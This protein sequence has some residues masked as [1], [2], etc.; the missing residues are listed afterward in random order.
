[1]Y[2]MVGEIVVSPDT[3]N[4]SS[5]LLAV[6]SRTHGTGGWD[7]VGYFA[8]HCSVFRLL[9]FNWGGGQKMTRVPPALVL[10]R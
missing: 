8:P 7:A 3:L 5:R 10:F 9:L 6:S 2:V 1:M 4:V